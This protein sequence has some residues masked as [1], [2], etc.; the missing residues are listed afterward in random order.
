MRQLKIGDRIITD[1]DCFVIAE[2]GSNHMGDLELA[3]EMII[4]AA[5]CG[6][7][8]VKFQVRDN[9]K[10]FTKS[11]LDSPYDNELSYGKTYGEHREH[12]DWFGKQELQFLQAVADKHGILFF[13]TPFEEKSADLLE[14]LDVPLYKIASCDVT[15]IPLIMHVAEFGKPMIISTGGATMAEIHDLWF[16]LQWYTRQNFALLHCVSLYPNI[17]KTLNLRTIQTLKD[18]Y[19]KYII[20]FSSHHPG[21]L[22]LYIARTLGASIFE[23][24][25]T[26]SRG[27]R[28]T[29]HG[30]SFEPQGLKKLCDDLPRI[31]VMAG[32][33]EKKVQPGEKEGF[34]KKFGKGIYLK[35]PLKAGNVLNKEDICIKSPAGSLKP[36]ESGEIIGK[37]LINDVSTGICLERGDFD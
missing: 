24:H 26:M 30:F 9:T 3:E 21:L 6:A 18:T 2:I 13:A 22:P 35:R 34:I 33:Y 5:Y 37:T 27:N 12:L 25:F 17:D 32:S 4:E 28:G 8:A 31:G 1:N 15:N 29:D 23:V 7:D 14:S 36:H 11:L 10:M 19:K 20:G 16:K